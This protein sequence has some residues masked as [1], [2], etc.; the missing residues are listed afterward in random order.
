MD[1]EIPQG[2]SDALEA[3]AARVGVPSIWTFR[4][5]TTEDEFRH[6]TK[7]GGAFYDQFGRRLSVVGTKHAELFAAILSVV[8]TLRPNDPRPRA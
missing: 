1:E 6:G 2:L 8:E 3:D 4:E 7:F 5:A